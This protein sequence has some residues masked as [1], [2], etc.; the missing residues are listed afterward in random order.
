ML[1]EVQL[2]RK[3]RMKKKVRRAGLPGRPTLTVTSRHMGMLWVKKM[4]G[5]IE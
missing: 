4:T 3:F 1:K 5:K 2:R